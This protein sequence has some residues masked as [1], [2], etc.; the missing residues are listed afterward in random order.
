MA[1]T[2]KVESGDTGIQ[3]AHKLRMSFS[4]LESANPD[5]NWSSLQI[6]QVVKISN[7]TPTTNSPMITYTVVAGDTFFAIARKFSIS[8]DVLTGANPGVTPNNLQIG[9][10]LNVPVSSVPAV[11]TPMFPANHDPLTDKGT[12]GS[13]TVIRY[14]GHASNFPGPSRWAKFSVLWA[15]NAPVINSFHPLS[16]LQNTP[17]QTKFIHDA[18]NKVAAESGV[19]RRIILAVIM[20]ESHGDVHA[21]LTV[22]GDGIGNP[23]LMQSNRG[24]LFDENNQEESILQMIRDG[25]TGTRFGDGIKQCMEH[26]VGNVYAA[27]REYNSGPNATHVSDLWDIS[28]EAGQFG[29][30][31]YASDIANWLMGGQP[32]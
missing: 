18:I 29:V 7:S 17:Q 22:S 11:L 13:S 3:I 24:V 31:S 6:G 25:T 14:T 8:L 32:N 4:A 30:A 16:G 2:Y 5:V 27:V 26:H 20:Q 19:D 15:L 21:G 28:F 23:G 10:K 12:S 9:Q 1:S